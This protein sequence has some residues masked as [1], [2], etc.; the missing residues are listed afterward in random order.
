[1]TGNNVIP[2]SQAKPPAKMRERLAAGQGLNKNF[3]SGIRDS[4]PRMSIKGKVFSLKI[5]GKLETMMDPQRS[6]PQR[7]V[8]ATDVDVILLNSQQGMSKS[9]YATSF[10]DKAD[11]YQQPDCWSL[12]AVKP[13]DRVVNKV[14]P[15]C[16]ACPMNQFRSARDKDG[17]VRE[18][19]ACADSKRIVLMFPQQLGEEHPLLFLLRVPATSHKNMKRYTDHLERQGW[20]PAGCVTRLSFDYTT[21]YPKVQFNFVDGLSDQEYE[22]M[23]MLAEGEVARAMLETPDFDNAVSGGPAPDDEQKPEMTPRVR[24]PMPSFGTQVPEGEPTTI[25][26]VVAK[27]KPHVVEPTLV[28]LPTGELLDPAT[29]EIVERPAPKVDMP[30]LDPDTIE[31]KPDGRFWNKAQNAFVV[32][33]EK[34]AKQVVA[35]TSNV[36]PRAARGRKPKAKAEPVAEAQP[37]AEPS[38]ADPQVGEAEAK[39]ETNG[40]S[41]GKPSA[42]TAPAPQGLESLLQSVLPKRS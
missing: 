5:D 1:M 2:I 39:A 38:T 4:F 3:A 14:N 21:A 42:K 27:E 11:T 13:D 12:D 19:K 20:E 41:D 9:F 25:D 37:A 22:Q 28:E 8:P 26:K 17:N 6:T 31:I 29:G 24:K 10:D 36:R 16:P 15:T 34:G 40:A 23:M 7:P 32:G 35:E 30:E 33:P 18:G